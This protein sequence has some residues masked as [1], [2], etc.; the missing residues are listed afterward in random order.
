MAVLTR[1]ADSKGRITLP[2]DFAGEYVYVERIADDELVLRKAKLL[3]KR[4]PKYRLADLL[5]LITPE[6]LHERIDFGKPRGK[7]LL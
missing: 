6:N 7:E 3:P 1:K 4:K 5:K 2:A